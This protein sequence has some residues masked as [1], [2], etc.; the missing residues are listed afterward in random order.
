MSYCH[1]IL[2]VVVVVDNKVCCVSRALVFLQNSPAIHEK[3]TDDILPLDLDDLFCGFA[4][5]FVLFVYAASL[6]WGELTTTAHFLDEKLVCG[7][8][9]LLLEVG[10]LVGV[11]DGVEESEEMLFAVHGQ[12]LGSTGADPEHAHVLWVGDGLCDVPDEHIGG[13]LAG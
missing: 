1:V 11:L 9:Q 6:P 5:L 8:E 3:S 12:R 7:V 13:A 4:S 2:L 10:V